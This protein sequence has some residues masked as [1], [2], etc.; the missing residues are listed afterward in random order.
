MTCIFEFVILFFPKHSNFM[1]FCCKFTK[2]SCISAKQDIWR[3]VKT[4]ERWRKNI[5]VASKDITE[6][7][8]LFPSS[9]TF[10]IQANTRKDEETD[11]FSALVTL[12]CAQAHSLGRQAVK[13]LHWGAWCRRRKSPLTCAWRMVLG[14]YALRPNALFWDV[15][16]KNVFWFFYGLK[17][18]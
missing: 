17:L 9:M 15:F 4:L 11:V 3:I 8:I 6:G 16:V 12:T 10:Y 1:M 5:R 14:S 18:K 2:K 7:G 13:N